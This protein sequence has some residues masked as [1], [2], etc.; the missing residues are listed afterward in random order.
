MTQFIYSPARNVCSDKVCTSFVATADS[1]I[2][3]TEYGNFREGGWPAAGGRVTI[4][5]FGA[6]C[7]G[8]DIP[9]ISMCFFSSFQLAFCSPP[10]N[11]GEN[12]DPTKFI[13]NY[14]YFSTPTSIQGT[15]TQLRWSAVLQNATQTSVTVQINIEALD[16]VSG[17]NVWNDWYSNTFS[18]PIVGTYQRNQGNNFTSNPQYIPINVQNPNCD[19]KFMTVGVGLEP[20]RFG[21]GVGQ[22]DYTCGMY[23]GNDYITCARGLVEDKTGAILPVP[24]LFGLN[25]TTCG[26]PTTSFCNC[27]DC[28]V[29]SSAPFFNCYF[30]TDPDF[31]NYV[32]TNYA[33]PVDYQ[34]SI[35]LGYL[36]PIPVMLKLV[37]GTRYV[38]W[39]SDNDVTN[40]TRAEFNYIQNNRPSIVVAEDDKW[41]ITVYFTRFPSDDLMPDC[42]ALPA[43]EPVATTAKLS[44]QQMIAARASGNG[45]D[46]GCGRKGVQNFQGHPRKI[47]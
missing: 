44:M 1:A 33:E 35:Q 45:G 14:G 36:T 40:W 9:S 16:Q 11:T 43:A 13:T 30:N 32:L 31:K 22:N 4:Q 20:L 41:K 12:Y 23:D 26:T 5:F 47:K 18:L 8:S 15:A 17:T 37:S 46:C 6:P 19:I 2:A 29:T 42:E 7:P 25:A 27:D 24:F 3:C 39:A 21:C 10:P 34:Q 38:Y 28:A